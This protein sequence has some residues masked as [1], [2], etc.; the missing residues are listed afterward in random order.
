MMALRVPLRLRIFFR[1]VFLLL[2]LATLALAL[3]VLADEK[4]RAHSAYAE[5]LAKSRAQI[6]A[7]LRHPTGQ[8]MLMNPG[9]AQRPATP[10][11]PLLLPYSALDFD[12]RA[13]AWQAV[14]MAGCGVQYP[15][16]ALLC[17][18]LGS[19][20][21]AGGFVY[22]VGRLAL[23]ELTP[24][25]SGDLDFANSHRAAVELTMRG[26]IWRWIAPFETLPPARGAAAAGGAAGGG[27]PFGP[28]GPAA[29]P[30]VPGTPGTV[31]RLTGYDADQP[32]THGSKPVRDF[33]AWLWQEG[34]CADGSAA[35]G[36]AA[37][38]R[39][40]YVSI[41]LPVE[42]FREALAAKKEPP[43]W[44][45]PD[46]ADIT[47]RLKLLAPG[48]NDAPPLFDSDSAGAQLPVS[49]A[50]LQGL[51][52]PG[53]TLTV[54]REGSARVLL[55][56]AGQADAAE[57]LPWIDHLVRRLPVP[58]AP[59]PPAPLVTHEIVAT[60]TGRHDV[61]L[62]G[63][64]RSVNRQLAAVATRVSGFV[65]AMLVAI[66]LA[67]LA[68]EVRIIRRVTLLTRRAAAV[69]TRMREGQALQLDLKDLRGS[70]ELGVLAQ[71]LRDLLQRV[72]ADVQREQIR[73]RQEKDQWH[74]VGHEI[75]SPLQSLLALHGDATD[76]A[77]R[78]LVRM[79]QAVRVLYGQAS[80][81]EAFEATTLELGPLDL[82]AFLGHVAANAQYIGIAG[83]RYASPGVA[84]TVRADEHSLEDVVT[85]LLKNA[86]RHRTPGTPITITLAAQPQGWQ[87]AV[88][89]DGPP[90]PQAM[91]ERVFEYGVSGDSSAADE[92][93]A[94]HRGQGLFVARTYLAKM[95]GTIVARNVEGGVEFVLALPRAG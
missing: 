89:N 40:S 51:L 61:T 56:L 54:R 27:G 28:S 55:Q 91:L 46:I 86:D 87:V 74:A 70:D 88:H 29:V 9:V 35:A 66:L 38:A 73:A 8:L 68:I 49:P 83:V 94:G 60:P 53:E 80:P 42:P 34:R 11:K 75:V 92:P 12:D 58:A 17:A 47:L 82:D 23:G 45:P 90:I 4:E 67:W 19:N 30:V 18:G 37:C 41:R 21:Y 62:A 6:A 72:D 93:A 50:E 20:P 76:P 10:L 52:L 24:H 36:D 48:P 65:G 3:V 5:R 2:A 85:H 1:G 84:A 78:Y 79:Q 26:R 95:G 69:S 81:S 16:G 43:A 33:R 71:G 32:I 39:R 59:A 15:D 57:P 64:L 25:F 14:E 63:D 22:L 31:G 77:H 44:P 13:K 7:R